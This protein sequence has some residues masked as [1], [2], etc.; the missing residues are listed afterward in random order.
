M[1]P[2]CFKDPKKQHKQRVKDVQSL[3]KKL[4]KAGW[5]DNLEDLDIETLVQG[6]TLAD[7]FSQQQLARLP[8]EQLLVNYGEVV[9]SKQ[10]EYE[11]QTYTIMYTA[12][13]IVAMRLGQCTEELVHKS[14]G[15]LEFTNSV[16]RINRVAVPKLVKLLDVLAGEQSAQ[17]YEIPMR[18]TYANSLLEYEI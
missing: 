5:N 9:K 4:A 18:R 17:A 2:I 11:C 12:L 6:L 3:L 8:W 15:I 7:K 10:N 1:P 16:L 13:S 14:M